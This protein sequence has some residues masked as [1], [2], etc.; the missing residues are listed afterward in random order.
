MPV[1]KCFEAVQGGET[2]F[3]RMGRIAEFYI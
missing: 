1:R 3:H 2:F